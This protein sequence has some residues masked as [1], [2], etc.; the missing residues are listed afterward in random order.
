MANQPTEWKGLE[1]APLEA[2]L[3]VADSIPLPESEPSPGALRPPSWSRAEV[4]DRLGGDEELMRE[5]CQ[6]FLKESPKLME[7]LRQGM[8]EG[9]AE[10]VQR[11]AHSLK[12][13][14]SYLSAAGATQAARC[15]ED[16]GH[17]RD[18]SLASEAI[19]LME[20]ELDALRQAIEDDVGGAP[21]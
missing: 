2:P 15:L 1:N 6:I 14:V 7:K 4:L 9:D 8:A 13:E 11:A 18:L 19:R 12:G 20:R 16:M 10:A 17:G 3:T 5:L 21:R